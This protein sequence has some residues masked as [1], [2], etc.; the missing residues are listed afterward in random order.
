MIFG[1]SAGRM[2]LHTMQPHAQGGSSLLEPSLSTRKDN[3]LPAARCCWSGGTSE[4]DMPG[5][6]MGVAASHLSCSRMYLHF[7]H[8]DLLRHTCLW[9]VGLSPLWLAFENGPAMVQAPCSPPQLET[10]IAMERCHAGRPC[11]GTRSCWKT[12]RWNDVM[13]ED[14]ASHR[15]HHTEGS[16]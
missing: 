14:H 3:Q 11:D 8:C 1:A 13:L 10:N 9:T 2:V 15:G 5:W 7:K 12:M 16:A 4:A 6:R